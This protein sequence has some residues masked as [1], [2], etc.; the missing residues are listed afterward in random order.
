MS[1]EFLLVENRFFD[2]ILYYTC[3]IDVTNRHFVIRDVWRI[4]KKT[5][6][7]FCDT[8]SIEEYKNKEKPETQYGLSYTTQDHE[9]EIIDLPYSKF[10]KLKEFLA[11]TCV[12]LQEEHNTNQT[13]ATYQTKASAILMNNGGNRK[14][15]LRPQQKNSYLINDLMRR[16][17]SSYSCSALAFLSS[18]QTQTQQDTQ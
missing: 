4:A 7:T 9:K 15:F 12:L 10:I 17:P 14:K 18:R 13:K 5:Q 1:D 6:E 3:S 8:V 16:A 2:E 11:Q